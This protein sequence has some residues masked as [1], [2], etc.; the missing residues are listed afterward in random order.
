MTI[1]AQ[2]TQWEDGP[3][4]K[5]CGH[6]MRGQGY[7]WV[8]KYT[9][10]FYLVCRHCRRRLRGKKRSV[11]AF[12]IDWHGWDDM[13]IGPQKKRHMKTLGKYMTAKRR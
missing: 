5:Y 3:N 7:T 4:C 6:F 10:Y 1:E 2:R 8:D 11:V 13:L 12:V 9:F